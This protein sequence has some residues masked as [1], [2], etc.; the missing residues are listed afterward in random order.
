MTRYEAITE[1]VRLQSSGDTEVAHSD[2][3]EILCTL[4]EGLGYGDVVKQYHK[5]DKWFA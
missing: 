4:L 2:A 5:V 3:D 1:L